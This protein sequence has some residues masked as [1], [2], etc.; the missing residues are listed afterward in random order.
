MRHPERKGILS[1]DYTPLS[2]EGHAPSCPPHLKTAS[3]AKSSG[4]DGAC[5]SSTETN[6][7]N[8]RTK[9][10]LAGVLPLLFAVVFAARAHVPVP[11]SVLDPQTAPEAWNVLRLVTDNAD[12][13]LREDRLAELPNQV[14]LGSPALRTLSRLRPA[15]APGAVRAAVAVNS[16]AQSGLVGDRPGAETALATLRATLAEMAPAFDAQTVRADIFTCP[17]HPEVVTPDPAAPCPKCGMA[18]H[19][20][21]IPYSFIYV[22]PGEPSI[23]LT[24][25]TEAP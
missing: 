19:P 17:M 20:R 23:R 13:L 11:E 5:P 10:R 6:P 25:A 7:R 12:R 2:L 22:P 15:V 4:H 18:L 1:A 9:L 24:A 16:A 8:L 14:S 3:F 21:R